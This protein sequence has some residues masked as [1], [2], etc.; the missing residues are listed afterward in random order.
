MKKIFL[1][2]AALLLLIPFGCQKFLDVNHDPDLPEE[3]TVQLV[4]PSAMTGGSEVLGGYVMMLGQIWSQQ[5]TAINFYH[6]EETFNVPAGKYGYD[7][8]T[9]RSLYSGALMDYEWVRNTAYENGNWT[10]YLI[11]TVMQSYTYQVLA[12][13]WEDIPVSEALKG[14]SP[15]YDYGSD[16]YDTLI[17]RID[18]ALAQDLEA[19][20]CEQPGEDDLIFAGNM[21]DWIA[22]ANTLKLKMYLRESV[23]RPDV[24]RAGIEPLLAADVPLLDYT[25]ATYTAFSDEESRDNFMYG[26][27]FRGGNISMRA[28]KT[29]IDY[30]N[31][32]NDP[33]IDYIYVKDPAATDHIGVFQGDY[34]NTYTEYN[35][36]KPMLSR[37]RITPT[38]P[39][40][41]FTKAQVLLMLAEAELRFGNA[42]MAQTYYEAAMVAD[43]DRLNALFAS[44]ISS[45][46][47][48]EI[49]P[50]LLDG[51]ADY[52]YPVGGSIDQIMEKIILQKWIVSANVMAIEAFFEHNRTGYPPE[53][54]YKLS[55]DEF[56]DY[57]DLTKG[58]W[59]QPPNS[60][61]TPPILF[62]KRLLYS[63]TEMNRNEFAPAE[64]KSINEPVW[65]DYQH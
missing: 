8:G 1:I 49:D 20:T 17:A 14:L 60:V 29:M 40:Y 42:G 50:V 36:Q 9:W 38:M 30:L 48:V 34:L 13:L 37:P 15:H 31:D 58:E 2:A 4:L 32:V 18:F 61:L 56:E 45:G 63:S 19:T 52:N 41:Y 25:D 28:S 57:Y 54:P 7:I 35:V 6:E 51:I 12:D 33:R 22:F 59:I 16:V 55:D 44:E 39:F 5:W 43:A 46:E 27:E 3:S 62:P 10:Y 24:A 26:M 65:W 11:A 23:V 64:V 53:A 21:N 47:L